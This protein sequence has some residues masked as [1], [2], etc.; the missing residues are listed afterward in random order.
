MDLNQIELSQKQQLNFLVGNNLAI[1]DTCSLLHEGAECFWKNVVPVLES[2]KKRII[3]PEEVVLEIQKHCSSQEAGLKGKAVKAF[4]NL[5]ALAAKDMISVYGDSGK[6]VFA[7][8]TIFSVVAR[9]RLQY[10]LLVITNDQGLAKDLENLNNSNAVK[11][12]TIRVRKINRYGYLS[13]FDFQKEQPSDNIETGNNYSRNSQGRNYPDNTL[14]PTYNCQP[15]TLLYIAPS[16]TVVLG[17][18]MKKGGEALLFSTNNSSYVVKLFHAKYN[19]RFRYQKIKELIRMSSIPNVAWPQAIVYSDSSCKCPVGYLMKRIEGRTLLSSV[20]KAKLLMKYY[21][22][23]NKR[24]DLIRIC[25]QIMQTAKILHEN[26]IL[27]GDVSAKNI[28]LKYDGSICFVD[29]DSCL[30]KGYRRSVLT[31][32]FVAPELI[33]DDKNYS[34]SSEYFELAMLIFSVLHLGKH[35]YSQT[36]GD[37]PV[38]DTAAGDFSFPLKEMT[39]GKTSAGPFRYMWS[40]LSFNTKKAFYSTFKAGEEH[41]ESGKRITPGQWIGILESYLKAMPKMKENDNMADDLFPTRFKKVNLADKGKGKV[42]CGVFNFKNIAIAIT[43]LIA[44]I[45]C[46]K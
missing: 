23:I 41:Y 8:N 36:G 18:Q 27:I 46:F 17:E 44:F 26:G 16:K 20:F 28:M 33:N 6:Q 14:I 7:D 35:P 5:K 24:S 4:K 11:N 9:F 31:P 40:H 39:N 25:I 12:K 45:Y 1:I 34:K 38:T 21:P 42:Q 32:M 30:I 29:I 15:G 19:T 22:A 3:V 10:Q 2:Y 37:D 43:A 13:K